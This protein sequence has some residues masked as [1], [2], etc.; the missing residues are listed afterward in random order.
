MSNKNNNATAKT[1]TMAQRHSRILYTGTALDFARAVHADWIS[2]DMALSR[3]EM[4]MSELNRVRNNKS[5]I[6]FIGKDERIGRLGKGHGF[7]PAMGKVTPNEIARFL[8]RVVEWIE[9]TGYN[10]HAYDA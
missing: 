10:W 5:F 4:V 2:G 8:E 9:T 7:N 3:M 6:K 1:E